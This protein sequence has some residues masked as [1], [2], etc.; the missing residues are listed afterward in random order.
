L[1][2]FSA[3]AVLG[4]AY[5]SVDSD[6]DGLV[7]GMEYLIGTNPLSADSD[8]DGQGDAIEFPQVGVS[9]SDPCVGPTITCLVGVDEIFADG[10]E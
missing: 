4:Y 3:D 1:S 6:S 8:G 9:T 2:A 5:P 10:F 7:D